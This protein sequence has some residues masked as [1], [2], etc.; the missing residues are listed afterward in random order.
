MQRCLELMPPKDKARA[1]VE[2][3]ML[4]AEANVV[5]AEKRAAERAAAAAARPQRVTSYAR[6]RVTIEEHDDGGEDGDEGERVWLSEVWGAWVVYTKSGTHRA[7]TGY[8]VSSWR[9]S[10]Q[11]LGRC[12]APMRV[13]A[14]GVVVAVATSGQGYFCVEVCVPCS[15]AVLITVYLASTTKTATTDVLP[16]RLRDL[17]ACVVR[18][19]AASAA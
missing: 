5:A 12:P 2:E 13:Y 7:K 17:L 9:R 19:Q 11:D 1:D 10:V 3:E 14:K 4:R 8:W 6:A 18:R 15:P 16:D